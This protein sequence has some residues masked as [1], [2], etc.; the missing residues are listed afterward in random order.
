M[1]VEEVFIILVTVDYY[2]L[3]NNFEV[4][5]TK[6][7]NPLRVRTPE[8]SQLPFVCRTCDYAKVQGHI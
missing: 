8:S 7:L 6:L 4:A 5:I 1:Y 2:V 3:K